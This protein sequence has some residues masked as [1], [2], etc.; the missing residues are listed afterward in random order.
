V[1]LA[2]D[3]DTGA[4]I[5]VKQVRLDAGGET[6]KVCDGA[7]AY[8]RRCRLLSLRLHCCATYAMRCAL[9][10]LLMP[11]NCHVLRHGDLEREPDH[12]H[13]IRAGGASCRV[14]HASAR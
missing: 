1:Y 9:R 5:A 11:A 10:R 14:A 4:E 12:L 13:G 7:L 3:M 6:V 8:G 2:L